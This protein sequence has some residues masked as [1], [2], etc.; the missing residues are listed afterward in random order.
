MTTNS[1]DILAMMSDLQYEPTQLQSYLLGLVESTL[2]GNGFVTNPAMPFPFLLESSVLL[3]TAAI[4]RDEILTMRQFPQLANTEQ[5]LYLHMS[6]TDYLNMYA[7]P[8]KA[9]FYI[10]I[11]R[12]EILANTVQIGT[13]TTKKLTIGKQSNITVNGLVFTLQYPINLL[14]KPHGGIEVIYDT[15]VSSPLQTLTSNKITTDFV[16]IPTVT[17]PQDRVVFLRMYI[18]V[19][20]MQLTSYTASLSGSTSFSKVYTFNDDYFATRAFAQNTDG[21]WSEISVSYSTQVF[22]IRSPTLLL[23]VEDSTVTVVVPYVYYNTG[24]VN[25]NIRIDIYTT[26]GNVTQALGGNNASAFTITYQDLDNDDSGI[27]TSPMSKIATLS[28]IS[29][30]ILSGGVD[31]PTFT[32]RR[33]RVLTNSVGPVSTPISRTQLS[34]ALEDIGF[35]STIATDTLTGRTF[36]ATSDMPVNT[37]GVATGGIDTA[38]MTRKSTIEDLLGFSNAIDNGSRITITPSGL[39]KNVSGALVQVP[40]ATVDYVNSLTGV[41]LIDELSRENYMFSPLHYVLDTSNDEFSVRAYYLDNPVFDDTSYAASN[42]TLGLTVYSSN[43]RSIIRTSTGYRLQIRSTSNSVWKALDDTQCHLQ[44][45][46]I[47]SGG[48]DCVYLLGTLLGKTTTG[49]RIYQFDISSTWD[50]DENDQLMVESFSMLENSPR[51]TFLPLKVDFM[52]LWSVSDYSV[53]GMETSDVDAALGKF[54]LPYIVT[55]VYMEGISIRLGDA[56]SHL[57]TRSRGMIQSRVPQTY[58]TPIPNKYLKNVYELDP[59]TNLPVI[60]TIDGV[61]GPVI[62]HKAGDIV[63]DVNGNIDYLYNVGDIVRDAQG[64]IVYLSDR[65]LSRWWDIV[66]FDAAYKFSEDTTDVAYLKSVPQILVEWNNDTLTPVR[67]QVLDRTEILFHPTNT[68]KYVRAIVDGGSTVNL[69]TSQDITVDIYVTKEVGDN[70]NLTAAIRTST[71]SALVTALNT[72]T[73]SR[74]SLENAVLN[75]AG[76]DVLSVKISG[77][78]GSGNYDVI[79]LEDGSSKLTIGKVLTVRQDGTLVVTDSIEVNFIIHT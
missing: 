46:Y 73:V 5:S 39:Y 41:A 79:T 59:V 13:T 76:T 34:T 70:S 43:V 65:L 33:E 23:T 16:T 58:T 48:T 27:Y 42:D 53:A 17:N 51:I 3:T 77:L 75:A 29:D 12:D 6:D 68:L 32:T 36:L 25:K 35:N 50:I 71:I 31:A 28:V 45:A 44:L 63:Y 4:Q 18:Q 7:R 61:T 1:D 15:S 67:D 2:D 9:G 72:T 19:Q 52:L 66:L 62:L 22:D 56:L 37:S 74:I 55:G 69:Y 10:Y 26:K 47:P 11:S 54:Q 14:V 78:G 8:G 40:D 64:D 49:E 24:L 60:R 21:T 38:V 57:W 30:D 20:Q